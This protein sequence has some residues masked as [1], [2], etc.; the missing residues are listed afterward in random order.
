VWN[1]MLRLKSRGCIR[2]IGSAI[3][4]SKTWSTRSL[5]SLWTSFCNN[6]SMLKRGDMRNNHA[7]HGSRN[8]GGTLSSLHSQLFG[9][10]DFD[11]PTGHSWA[12]AIGLKL[13]N[14]SKCQCS[15]VATRTGVT[16][17][18]IHTDDDGYLTASTRQWESSSRQFDCPPQLGPGYA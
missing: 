3:A 11:S 1:W 7:L 10:S 17:K 16:T 6:L 8:H 14:P 18:F 4:A 2:H 15:C 5:I 12:V 13:P 9:N